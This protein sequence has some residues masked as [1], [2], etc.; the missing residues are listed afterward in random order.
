MSEFLEELFTAVSNAKQLLIVPHNDPDPD[1]IASA[2]ALRYLLTEKKLGLAVDI[3]YLGIIGRA[4]NKA[5]VRYLKRPLRHFTASDHRHSPFMALVDTQPGTGNNPLTSTDKASVVI[6]HHPLRPETADVPF[7]D[8]R[9]NVG[10]SSTILTEYLQAAK[11]T[12]PTHIATALFYGIKTDTMGLSRGAGL[13]DAA[14]YFYLQPQIDAKALVEIERAQVSATYFQS[15]AGALQAARVNKDAVSAYI[16]PMQYP[17]LAAEIADLL[18]RLEGVQWVICLGKYKDHLILAVRSRHRQGGAGSLALAIIAGEG[19]A[20]GHGTM[21]GGQI[22]LQG[23]APADLAKLLIE[24]GLRY[25][26]IA[27]ETPDISLIQKESG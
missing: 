27:P 22:P 18:L 23:A 7:A 12:L 14:A 6:D 20:G 1:A 17:D 19:T 16:G 26:N 4:E 24:N 5:L 8:V 9:A 10:S 11:L 13:A 2:V 25:L 3:A 21:A 15:L